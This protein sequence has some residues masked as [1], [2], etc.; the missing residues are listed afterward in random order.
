MMSAPAANPPPL[1]ALLAEAGDARRR[2][3]MAAAEAAEADAI[4]LARRQIPDICPTAE[5]R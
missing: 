2:G 1:R 3:D 4:R 5:A